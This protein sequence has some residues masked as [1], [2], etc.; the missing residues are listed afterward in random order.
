MIEPMN[1]RVRTFSH[2]DFAPESLVAARRGRRISVCL[3][4]RDE[5]RTVGAIVSTVREELTSEG[6]GVALVDQIVVIDDGSD[7]GTVSA[8]RRAGAEVVSSGSPRGKG[9]AMRLGLDETDG[10]IVVFLDADVE[11]FSSHFV[12]GLLGPMLS[13]EEG[14]V[15]LVKGF[16]ERPLDDKPFGGGRVT[17]LMARPAID[18]LFPHLAG[19][20][21]PLA[22]ESAA[23]REV[24][25]KT[26]IEA[27][28]GAELGLLIDV[29]ARYGTG[30]IAQVDLGV[31]VHRN[32]PLSELRHQATDV[33]RAALERADLRE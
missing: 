20:R 17:E 2:G 31:R 1:G 25:E 24:L 32:R 33:L 7:D 19:V 10:D 26:G 11:N 22:G 16:Y 18:L 28:Y 3:P 8:A 23:P 27:G 15:A 6:G 13:E 14:G 29:A 9:Q 21:Q 4:A 30:S 12:T 5:E